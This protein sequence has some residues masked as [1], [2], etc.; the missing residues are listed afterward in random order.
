MR[1]EKCRGPKVEEW[2]LEGAARAAQA[3]GRD[4][5]MKERTRSD[6]YAASSVYGVRQKR[7]C[8]ARANEMLAMHLMQVLTM[9]KIGKVD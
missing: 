5:R 3:R 8:P 2:S 1:R 6:Q 9:R 4:E 7:K